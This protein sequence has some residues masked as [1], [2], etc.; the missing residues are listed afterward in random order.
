V[1]A[2]AR[3]AAKSRDDASITDATDAAAPSNEVAELYDAPDGARCVVTKSGDVV[4]WRW[5]PKI[6]EAR[7]IDGLR[8]VAHISCN[9]AMVCG[10]TND[11]TWSCIGDRPFET[12]FPAG[13][14]LTVS[15]PGVDRVFPYMDGVCAIGDESLYCW[16]DFG[17]HVAVGDAPMRIG[18]P[19]VVKFVD[20]GNG[21]SLIGTRLGDVY[22]WGRNYE[23]VCVPGRWDAFGAPRKIGA[24]IIDIAATFESST[25]LRKDGTVLTT[26]HVGFNT[27]RRKEHKPSEPEGDDF[28]YSD[29]PIPLSI[30][31]RVRTLLGDDCFELQSG[32][33]G[34]LGDKWYPQSIEE[35]KPCRAEEGVVKCGEKVV[36]VRW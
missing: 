29:V 8:G 23:G 20:S 14:V 9:R 35:L 16:G 18:L 3:A 36:P 11:A 22:C 28:F 30:P 13:N 21:W 4:K 15:L 5:A 32:E 1:D 10:Q 26:G 25:L 2:D 17:G 24:G 27:P 33:A 7:V 34:C 31:G 12:P 19:A 6:R